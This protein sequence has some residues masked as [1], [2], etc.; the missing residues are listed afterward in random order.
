MSIENDK[1]SDAPETA[2]DGIEVTKVTFDENG[3]AVGLDL[4]TL[5]DVSGGM[6]SNNGSC[7]SANVGSC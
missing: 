6:M 3:E 7:P 1:K 4:E 2:K 5:D